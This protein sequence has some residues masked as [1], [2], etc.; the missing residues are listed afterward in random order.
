MGQGS[1]GVKCVVCASKQNDLP[2]G[3]NT[4][5]TKHVLLWQG[6]LVDYTTLWHLTGVRDRI[7]SQLWY[8]SLGSDRIK[9]RRP[10]TVYI[11]GSHPMKMYWRKNKHL[12][13]DNKATSWRTLIVHM[14]IVPRMCDDVVVCSGRQ[15]Q[16]FDKRTHIVRH[17]SS[18][19]VS[20]DY[21]G[22]RHISKTSGVRERWIYIIK[23]IHWCAT[24]PT[25]FTVVLK[26]QVPNDLKSKTRRE[27][28]PP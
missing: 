28:D 19:S 16:T 24:V 18:V 6:H 9:T 11:W 26:R 10:P 23:S 2:D 25:T 4:W 12:V 21:D 5:Y 17:D 20:T 22:M 27:N 13:L 3:D 1:P 8:N 7:R 15:K 14:G